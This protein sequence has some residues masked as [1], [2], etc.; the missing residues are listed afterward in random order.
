MNTES[1]ATDPKA[2]HNCE[3]TEPELG[4]AVGKALLHYREEV[5]RISQHELAGLARVSRSTIQR[6]E[7]GTT[8]DY[9]LG[10][11]DKI[12]SAIGL[13]FCE[14]AAKATAHCRCDVF[15]G[16]SDGCLVT[17]YPEQGAKLIALIPDNEAFFFGCLYIN[18]Q[19]T[20]DMS[21]LPKWKNMIFQG[22]AGKL[23]FQNGPDEHLLSNE[24]LLYYQHP[25]Y[26]S[27]IYNA[28]QLQPATCFLVG[29]KSISPA[30]T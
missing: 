18:A 15:K 5:M 22:N 27:T 16:S 20:V 28:H 9:S 12:I 29:V 23:L 11:L 19:A 2:V 24:K 30:K 21:F 10:L 25:S 26:P 1:K 4:N 8:Q 14:F 13:S 7:K 3:G 6:I 17:E